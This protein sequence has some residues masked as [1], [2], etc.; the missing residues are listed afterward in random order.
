VQLVKDGVLQPPAPLSTLLSSI[1][2]TQFSIEQVAPPDE[3]ASRHAVVIVVDR[4]QDYA[5]EKER[6]SKSKANSKNPAIENPEIQLTWSITPHDLGHKL[7]PAK[8]SLEKGGKATLIISVK[9][10]K[11][12]APLRDARNVFVD[13]VIAE[14]GLPVTE[15]KDREHMGPVTT[16]VLQ[17]KLDS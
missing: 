2:R 11:H 13:Q 10:R 15:V 3:S 8:K 12:R 7:G 4:K 17:G 1:D 9:S 6:K 14:L 16:I 5:K